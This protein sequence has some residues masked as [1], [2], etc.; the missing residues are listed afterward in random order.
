MENRRSRSQYSINK[1]QMAMPSEPPSPI[2]L[3]S[4]HQATQEKKTKMANQNLWDMFNPLNSTS[5]TNLL[6]QQLEKCFVKNLWDDFN[7]LNPTSPTSLFQQLEKCF[8]KE[9]AV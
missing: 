8:V 1:G 9:T 5:P 7:P 2:H 6:Q 3:E 4:T